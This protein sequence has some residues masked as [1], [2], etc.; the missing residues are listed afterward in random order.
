MN[1]TQ[2]TADGN[3]HTNKFAK[4]D[5]P[6]DMSLFAGKAY[7]PDETEYKRYLW[8]VKNESFTK[9][10]VLSFHFGYLNEKSDNDAI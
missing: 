7:F 9:E 8:K 2:D 1:Q 10:E 4:N 6:D 5:D 3:H